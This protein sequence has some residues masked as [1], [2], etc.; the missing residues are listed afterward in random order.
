MK[1]GM[2]ISKIVSTVKNRCF[3]GKPLLM[4]QPV[5]PHCRPTGSE[6][7]CIDFVG[8]DVSEL[9]LIMQEGSSVQDMLANPDAPADAA[10]IG[11]VDTVSIENEKVFDKTKA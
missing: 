9:V 3:E 11:V 8:A 10:I 1:L 4:V 2:V 5:D 7:L 6:V